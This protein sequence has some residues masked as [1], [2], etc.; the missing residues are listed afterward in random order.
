MKSNRVVLAR[1]QGVVLVI[2][3][4]MLLL[5][6]IIG[7]TSMQ[8]TVLEETMAGAIRDK[9][10]AFNLAEAALQEG[11]EYLTAATLPAFSD[12]N[13][14]YSSDA[15]AEEL[16]KTVSWDASTASACNC[17][18]YPSEGLIGSGDVSLPR[19]IIEELP[20]S[21]IAAPSLVV[22][23]KPEAHRAL[24]QLTARGEGKMGGVAILQSTYLR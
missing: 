16:W 6:T 4:I 14:L 2:S 13:G 7:V 3:M 24:Y 23:F 21:T 17:V 1:Q 10:I 19:Y 12:S 9:H 18:I 15:T 22:G 20:E 5:M 11:E 8:T